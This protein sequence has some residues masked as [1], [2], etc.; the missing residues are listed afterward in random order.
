MSW[1]A[2]SWVWGQD[3]KAGPKW[4]L[5]GIANYT[6]QDDKCWPGI[7]T[8]AQRLGMTKQSVITHIQFLESKGYLIKQRNKHYGT[9]TY[10]LNRKLTGQKSLPDIKAGKAKTGQKSLPD[11][12]KIFELK[13]VKNFDP[14]LVS[15]ESIN[16]PKKSTV[17]PT[18]KEWTDKIYAINPERYKSIMSWVN[19]AKEGFTIDLIVDTLRS[20]APRAGDPKIENWWFYLRRTIENKEKNRN[21][22]AEE[23]QSN[24]YKQADAET[25]AALFKR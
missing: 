14:N 1:E 4:V 19:T 25:A 11:Q 20:F 2:Q 18:I 17:D 3:I 16:Q 13:Q 10:Q 22:M 6:D 12:V 7:D 8:L 5:M 21:A 15:S 9:N 23:K 24:R